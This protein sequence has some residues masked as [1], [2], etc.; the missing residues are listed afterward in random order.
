MLYLILFVIIILLIIIKWQGDKPNYYVV[1]IFNFIKR[2]I[3]FIPF[4][5]L[6][7]EGFIDILI[8]IFLQL[9]NYVVASIQP[10]YKLIFCWH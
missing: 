10:I 6:G 9:A 8:T 7:I 2:K 4:Y 3:F 1:K 5:E